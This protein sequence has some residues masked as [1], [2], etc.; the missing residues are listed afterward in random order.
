MAFRPCP[1]LGFRYEL[2]A[3]GS[4]PV[5]TWVDPEAPAG[6]AGLRQGDVIV[7]VDG[8]P[9]RQGGATAQYVAAVATEG[10]GDVLGL[11]H[12]GHC[13]TLRL[14]VCPSSLAPSTA[15]PPSRVLLVALSDP[16]R[17]DKRGPP[18]PAVAE[19]WCGV[20]REKEE[21]TCGEDSVVSFSMDSEL[22]RVAPRLAA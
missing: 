9:T 5:V 12:K 13:D 14:A 22:V 16:A 20:Q 11:L 3:S 15:A 1:A 21:A 10:E 17:P 18:V 6:M 8:V 2:P 19:N 4:W 7:S